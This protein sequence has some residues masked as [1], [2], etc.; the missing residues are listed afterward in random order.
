MNKSNF[1]LISAVVSML[2]WAAVSNFTDTDELV[3]ETEYRKEKDELFTPSDS[4]KVKPKKPKKS[5]R[6]NFEP[7]DRYGDPYSNPEP[8]TP[9]ILKNPVKTEVELDS[10]GKNYIIHEKVNGVEYRPPS[11]MTFEEYQQY[12][13]KESMRQYWINK[14]TDPFKASSDTSKKKSSALL[15]IPTR[16]L[17]GP[18]GG[19][20]V[21]IRPSGLV[22]LDFAGKWQRINNP[23]IPIRQQRNGNFDFDQQISMNVVGQLGQK[24]KITSNWDTK[25]PFDF[26]NNIKLEFTGFQE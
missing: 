21:E 17:G 19:D 9:L 15:K 20:F 10:S 18:F 3:H 5:A 2:T 14:R 24:L 12:K 11:T 22:T 1:F 7:Q 13:N 25:A 8:R 26:Q 16:G 23:N 6:P 4:G